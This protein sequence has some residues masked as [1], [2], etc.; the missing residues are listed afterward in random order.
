MKIIPTERTCK[1]GAIGYVEI[2]GRVL[3]L[4]CFNGAK[5]DYES[6]FNDSGNAI[7]IDGNTD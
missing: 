3:C 6:K 5:K 7:S 2:D 1:C 4:D